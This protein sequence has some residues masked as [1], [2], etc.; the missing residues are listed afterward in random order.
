MRCSYTD[1]RRSADLPRL[2]IWSGR[3]GAAGPA[4]P[5][6]RCRRRRR[7]R[8][9]MRWRRATG[10]STPRTRARGRRR[11]TSDRRHPSCSKQLVASSNDGRADRASS[12]SCGC[13]ALCDR[14]A[15]GPAEFPSRGE[16]Q[17]QTPSGPAASPSYCTHRC[18]VCARLRGGN[19][20]PVPR[21]KFA[22]RLP[23]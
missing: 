2:V 8:T 21:R 11:W 20:V 16:S 5:A 7:A 3:R 4:A 19:R 13:R 14:L 23:S 1:G 15:C 10:T 12:S 17:S 6:T 9:R 22:P 18:V